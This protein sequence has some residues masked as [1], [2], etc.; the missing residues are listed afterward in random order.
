M[1]IKWMEQPCQQQQGAGGIVNQRARVLLTAAQ[2]QCFYD[3]MTTADK[4]KVDSVAA[5]NPTSLNADDCV[6]LMQVL[7]DTL[8]C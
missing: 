4:A 1:T 8:H 7:D 6:T 3:S 5:K 2:H